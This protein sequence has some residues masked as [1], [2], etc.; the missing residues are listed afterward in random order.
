MNRKIVFGALI[1]GALSGSVLTPAVAFADE[2]H[3]ASPVEVTET[4]DSNASDTVL[5]GETPGAGSTPSSSAP[6]PG[7]YWELIKPHVKG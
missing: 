6:L 4:L 3:T 5:A 1:A 2:D 7:N